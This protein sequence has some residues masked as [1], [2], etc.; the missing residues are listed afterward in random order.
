M[1]TLKELLARDV[2]LASIEQR[3]RVRKPEGAEWIISTV[4]APNDDN[5]LLYRA[6][7]GNAYYI[8]KEA[9]S[10]H[11]LPWKKTEWVKLMPLETIAWMVDLSVSPQLRLDALR[12]VTAR[13]P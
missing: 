8:Q 13:K 5:W 4:I 12:Q 7:N 1:K 2:S 9:A 11:E 10:W 3:P 6:A